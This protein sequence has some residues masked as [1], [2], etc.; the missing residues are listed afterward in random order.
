MVAQD[1]KEIHPPRFCYGCYKVCTKVEKA[2]KEGRDYT[3]RLTLFE[4]GEHN[5]TLSDK[6]R[7]AGR[8]AKKTPVGRPSHKTLD[9]VEHLKAKAPENASLDLEVRETLSRHPR[10]DGGLKCGLCNLIFD[11][12]LQLVTCN[13]LVCMKCCVG[14]AYKHTDFTCPCGS[15]HTIDTSTVIPAPSVIITLLNGLEVTCEGCGRPKMAGIC[16]IINHDTLLNYT[17]YPLH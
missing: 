15:G 1:K 12:P 6:F 14:H 9:F 11:R 2:K 10:V 17:T 7:K 3:P 13:M 16:L 4:W 5:E 8:K